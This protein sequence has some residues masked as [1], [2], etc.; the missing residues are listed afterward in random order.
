MSGKWSDSA[1]WPGYFAQVILLA[2][3]YA[4]LGWLGLQLAIPP[5]F[6]AS[7][8]P[9]AGVALAVLLWRGTALWP[10]VWLG[11]FSLNL[12]V[13]IETAAFFPGLQPLAVAA[14]IATGAVVQAVVSA[15]LI[16]RRIRDRA[17]D[18]PV[19]VTGDMNAAESNP[20]IAALKAPN[21]DYPLRDTFRVVHPDAR[22]VGTGNGGYTGKRDGAKIDYVLV[23]EEFETVD[24]SIDQAPRGGRYP[25]DHY[26]VLARVRLRAAPN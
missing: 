26:P 21:S 20:A 22:E 2:V 18:D 9:A 23:S 6:A 14:G 25:S 19:L 12:A 5:G 1:S 17:T 3:A 15:A 4:L 16:R 10:G 13:S 8:W 11:S 7:I 24:A